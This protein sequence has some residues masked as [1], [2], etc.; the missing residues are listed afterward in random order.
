MAETA[1]LPTTSG[2]VSGLRFDGVSEFRGIPYAGPIGGDRRFR[3]PVPPRSW[4]QTYAATRWPLMA[5][6]PWGMSADDEAY[7]GAVFGAPYVTESTEDGLYLNL[8]TPAADGARR[9]VM[10]WL[11]GGGLLFGQAT[12]PRENG[13][14]LCA[15]QDVVVVAPSHRLGLLGYLDT[16]T[17]LG[18]D[19]NVGMRD[20]VLALEWIRDNIETFGGDPANVTLFGES[21]GGV[22]ITTLLAMPSAAG[23]FHRAICQSGVMPSPGAPGGLTPEQAQPMTEAVLSAV[24]DPAELRELPAAALATIPLPGG[25]GWQP[26]LDDETLPVPVAPALA[27]GAGADIPLILGTDAD[28][29]RVLMRGRGLPATVD[30]LATLLVGL[31]GL[32]GLSGAT[33]ATPVAEHYAGSGDDFAL[34]AERALGDAMFRIPTIRV[35]QLRTTAGGA[36]VFMYL[37]RWQNPARPDVGAGHGVETSLV[38]GNLADVPALRDAPAA[39]TLATMMAAAWASFARDG[40]PRV[41]G[42]PWPPYRPTDRATL[43]WDVPPTVGCDPGG[44]DRRAWPD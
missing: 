19:A 42:E 10:V 26:V 21:G 20:I 12:R 9:P 43:I 29:M 5:P 38:F 24:G 6:Q 44:P 16:R 14:R 39:D 13:R 37:L 4:T 31:G 11:H 7:Y 15:T 33:G 22:K 8:W 36:P 25:S 40:V 2:P 35:A 32:A 17:L 27:A 34:S 18:G 28:E 23:L 1:A 41:G 3:A 30:E